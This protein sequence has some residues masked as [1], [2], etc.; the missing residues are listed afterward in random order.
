M[1]E[2]DDGGSHPAAQLDDLVHQR[3]RLGILSVLAEAR[4]DFAYLKRVLGL[5]DGNLNSHL[6]VLARAG[7]LRA[8]K[9]ALAARGRTWVSIT[10]EGRA[11]LGAEIRALESLIARA[12]ALD[13]EATPAAEAD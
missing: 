13:P 2:T 11:A 8:E 5:T 6:G 1:P 3:A 12:Q 4:C 9:D 7:Y 10:P